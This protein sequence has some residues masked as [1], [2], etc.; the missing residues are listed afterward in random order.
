MAS[1]RGGDNP[2]KAASRA[3][4]DNEWVPSLMGETE[5]NEM[6]EAGVLPDRVTAG[7]RLADGEP[8]PMPHTDKVVVFEDYFWRGLELLVHP[9]LAGS[10]GVLG[11]ELV[12]FAST[13]APPLELKSLHKGTNFD[14]DLSDGAEE[15]RW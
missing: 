12:Q 3:S 8:Y 11:S 10:V 7:W 4:C 1:K 15:G 5:L 6:V 9:F 14:P 2:K 13:C